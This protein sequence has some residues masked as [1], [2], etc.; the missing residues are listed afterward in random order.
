[1]FR[2]CSDPRP[3]QPLPDGQGFYG[4]LQ[5]EALSCAKAFHYNRIDTTDFSAEG[6]EMSHTIKGIIFDLDGVL[7]DTAKY[8]FQAWSQL[9]ESLG[10][11]FTLEDNERLKGV[12]RLASLEILLSIGKVN[13]S[14]EE[15]KSAMEKKNKNYVNMISQMT[16]EGILPGALDLLLELKD[17]G[18]KTA[19][20]SASKNAPLIL[21]KTGLA[22]YLDAVVD[23]N[24]TSRAKPD[25]EVFLLAAEDLSLPPEECLVF[26]DAEAG[27]EAARNAGM[28]TVGIG[29]RDQLGKADLL[30]PDLIGVTWS[31]IS[32]KLSALGG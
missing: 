11:T 15:K 16:P 8:H 20:G 3:G 12:S 18:V 32:E 13:L 17:K 1:M 29:H 28:K 24:R 7:V 22:D 6:K 14:D 2:R 25:P 19:L 27:I 30:Y 10:F 21:E 23:G 5:I 31:R 4:D 9:G 26:E